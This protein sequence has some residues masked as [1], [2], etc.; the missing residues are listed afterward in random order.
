MSSSLQKLSDEEL[1][2]QKARALAG[3]KAIFVEEWRREVA[4]HGKMNPEQAIPEKGAA[5]SKK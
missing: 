3:L 1:R 5:G 4:K 2:A